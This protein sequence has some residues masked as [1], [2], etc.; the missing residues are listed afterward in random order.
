MAQSS[1]VTLLESGC[2]FISCLCSPIQA[3]NSNEYS[4]NAGQLQGL[5]H[6]SLRKW[7]RLSLA[8][9]CLLGSNEVLGSASFLYRLN[10]VCFC[11]SGV[12]TCVVKLNLLQLMGSYIDI[13]LI[14]IIYR[15]LLSKQDL[16]NSL[17]RTFGL[18]HCYNLK[19]SLYFK[20]FKH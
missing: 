6:G 7:V 1:G 5:D 8:A 15:Y 14:E 20:G 13:K 10:M 4:C 2:E 19:D 9:K 11:S 16:H 17:V 12:Y 18:D 3:S